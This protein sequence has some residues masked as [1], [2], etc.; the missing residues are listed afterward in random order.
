MKKL[1]LI[2]CIILSQTQV[3]GNSSQGDLMFAK[4]DSWV[5]VGDSITHGGDYHKFVY[6]YYSTRFPNE[7]FDIY[8]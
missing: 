4:G 1:I 7:Q 6:L 8:N 5:A 3:Y 2:I